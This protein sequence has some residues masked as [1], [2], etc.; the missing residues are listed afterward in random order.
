ADLLDSSLPADPHQ[1]AERRRRDGLRRRVARLLNPLAI[2]IPLLDPDRFLTRTLPAV[3]PLLGRGALALWSLVTGL[4]LLLAAMHWPEL[5][6]HGATRGLDPLNLALAVLV[7][8]FIKALHELGHAY[9]VKRAGGEV[10]ELGVMLLVFMP[11]P[12]CDA[13]AAA[14]FPD[15]WQRVAVGAAGIIVELGIAALAMLIW[16]L[17]EPGLL[18]DL[19]FNLMLVGGVLTLLF[20]GNPLL[21]FDGY[22]MLMDAIEIP[23]LAGRAQQYLACLGKRYLFGM[24][25]APSPV[26]ARGEAGWF[27]AYGL[28]AMAYRLVIIFSIALFVA[29]RFFVIGVLLALWAA[30][31][32]VLAPLWKFSRFLLFSPALAG[33]RRHV[34]GVVATLLMVAGTLLF[35]VPFPDWTRAEGIV[36]VPEAA[37]ARAGS[38][39]FI[40]RVLVANGDRVPAGTP[41]VELDDPLL[42]AELTELEWRLKELTAR[43][44]DV[45]LS[46]RVEA[47]ILA[48]EIDEVEAE[49]AEKRHRA[50]QLI[51]R[52]PSAGTV[53]VPGT[54]DLPGRFVEQGDV[55][56]YIGGGPGA[57]ARVVVTQQ[58][59]DRV[60]RHTGSIEVRAPSAPGQ[61]I[62]A[63]LAEA[64]PGASGQ[65]FSRRLGTLGGGAIAV[66]GRDASGTTSLD[67]VFQ[68]DVAISTEQARV[69]PGGRL[70][71]RF[72]HGYEPLGLQ[73]W[74]G[75]RQLLMSRLDV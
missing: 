19:A 35:V 61:T 23:N 8:P 1:L 28:A 65:L 56:A 31:M 14:A 2:R 15:K 36:R 60:R 72:N 27:V 68:F 45:F 63:Q 74:R 24:A 33:R 12:Y 20:N 10:H 51:V 58:Q 59:V 6:E 30:G 64:V 71:V 9:L 67:P 41:L 42:R 57:V 50:G 18:R 25:D 11:I 13:S 29:G 5:A 44:A 34:A 21:R 4:A 70:H 47:A 26:T 49:L 46:D 43:A 66:D 40:T 54:Y 75:L 37:T 53:T 3:R 48:A 22:F 69:Y 39:G 17:V 55:L 7:Y 52:S 73:W 16:L 32:Q 38:A 62:E